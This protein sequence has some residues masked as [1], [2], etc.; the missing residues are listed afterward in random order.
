MNK[1]IFKLIDFAA[2]IIMLSISEKKIMQESPAGQI[3][4]SEHRQL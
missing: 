4:R 2:L 1:Q 3:I